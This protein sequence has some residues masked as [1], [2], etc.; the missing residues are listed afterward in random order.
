MQKTILENLVKTSLNQ[1]RVSYDCTIKDAD[2]GVLVE[3][4]GSELNHLIG[5]RGDTLNALQHFLNAAYYN[6]AGEYVRVLVDINGYRDQRKD[7]LE[8]M[9]KNFIDRVR[10]FSQ[11]VE[12]PPMNP[13]ERRLVHTFVS[14]YDDVISESV[15]VGRDRRVVL[16]PKKTE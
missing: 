11:E 3:I 15:G 2:D 13:S 12:M 8:D 5:Y 16:K 9:A 10:F 7:K 1:L 6:G 14:E 4:T